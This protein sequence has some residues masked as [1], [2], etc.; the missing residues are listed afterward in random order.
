MDQKDLQK[1]KSVIN[2][3]EEAFLAK[4]GICCTWEWALGPHCGVHGKDKIE[5]A[6][7]E[8]AKGRVFDAVR[9]TP[10]AFQETA[11]PGECS[12]ARNSGCLEGGMSGREGWGG[13]RER[14][15]GKGGWETWRG[16]FMG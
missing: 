12:G 5:K 7:L 10:A 15:I 6:W 14:W 16:R 1:K 3:K 4:A 2:Y 9:W 11:P 8:M 13:S